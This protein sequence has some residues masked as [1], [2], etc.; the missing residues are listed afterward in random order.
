MID[1]NAI[2]RTVA[3]R[4]VA[5]VD[6]NTAD[7][8]EDFDEVNVVDQAIEYV[9]E[10]TP[11]PAHSA[12]FETIAEHRD[13]KMAIEGAWIIIKDYVSDQKLWKD[14]PAKAYGERQSDFV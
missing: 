9:I 8:A 14:G 13:V 12:L 2:A 6:A 1:T 11:I 4:I 10:G 7:Y 5:M 3:E